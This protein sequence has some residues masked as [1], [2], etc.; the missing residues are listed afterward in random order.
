MNS[1]E[2]KSSPKIAKNTG[3]G[4][5]HIFANEKFVKGSKV[6]ILKTPTKAIKIAEIALVI[7]NVLAN[8]AVSTICFLK[9]LLIKK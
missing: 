4:I 9:I 3:K 1:D 5:D 8:Y 2:I 7:L 6:I